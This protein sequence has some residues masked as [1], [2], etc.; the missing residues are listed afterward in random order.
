ML[1]E[2]HKI[3]VVFERLSET[4][5]AKHLK[6]SGLSPA[7]TC[8][9]SAVCFWFA[10]SGQ[11]T[12]SLE[13][14]VLPSLYASVVRSGIHSGDHGPGPFAFLGFCPFGNGRFLADDHGT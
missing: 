2:P 12:P 4:E 14:G 7:R 11:G 1:R 10:L 9:H 6:M 8:R 3:A 13:V 5:I